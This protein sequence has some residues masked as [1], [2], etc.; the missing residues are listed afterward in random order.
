MSLRFTPGGGSPSLHTGSHHVILGHGKPGSVT[1]KAKNGFGPCTKPN[2]VDGIE[3]SALTAAKVA[4]GD[5]GHGVPELGEG[6]HP[7]CVQAKAKECKDNEERTRKA[8]DGLALCSKPDGVDGN[9]ASASA[10]A[11]S[12]RGDFGHGVPK[13][14]VGNHQNCAQ[15]KVKA[16]DRG[17]QMGYGNGTYD[18]LDSCYERPRL[19]C[20]GCGAID[21]G[22]GISMLL[23]RN[24]SR[25]ERQKYEA[26]DVIILEEPAKV[27]KFGAKFDHPEVKPTEASRDKGEVVLNP[28]AEHTHLASSTARPPGSPRSNLEM[29]GRRWPSM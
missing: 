29:D 6:N 23:S 14:G 11:K 12:V 18:K 25:C 22:Q 3:A 26:S 10:T 8:N 9:Q 24:C 27:T 19:T 1:R 17:Q 20:K 7:D 2:N 21:L 4:S 13:F 28:D 16:K 15:A 5:F